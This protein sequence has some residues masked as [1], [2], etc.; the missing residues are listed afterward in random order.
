MFKLTNILLTT[1]LIQRKN[2]PISASPRFDIVTTFIFVGD[3][4]TFQQ[5]LLKKKE[6]FALLVLEHR[7]VLFGAF[8]DEKNI[9]K[10]PKRENGLKLI[11]LSKRCVTILFLKGKI[12]RICGIRCGAT[13]LRRSKRRW[14]GRDKQEK[15]RSR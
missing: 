3:M 9:T 6:P 1:Y 8:N 14:I 4:S 7:D 13:W 10:K 11:Q 12:G 15:E 2:C 5:S